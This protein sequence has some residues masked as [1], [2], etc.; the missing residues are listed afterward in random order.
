MGELTSTKL[1]N[2]NLILGPIEG[3]ES[4]KFSR[5]LSDYHTCAVTHLHTSHTDNIYIC[6]CVCVCVYE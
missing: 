2:V 6:V 1:A 4:T 5:F 3:N